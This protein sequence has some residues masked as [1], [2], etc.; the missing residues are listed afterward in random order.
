MVAVVRPAAEANRKFRRL[1]V[2]RSMK[3]L[4]NV[5]IGI[6]PDFHINATDPWPSW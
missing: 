6:L 3:S 5:D 2:S 1:M 4:I